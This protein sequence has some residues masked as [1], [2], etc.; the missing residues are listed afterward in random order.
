MD[1][2]SKA[3]M[4]NTLQAIASITYRSEKAQAKF[5]PGN[6]QHTLLKNRIKALYIASSLIE[7][8]LSESDVK[9]NFTK[10]ELE[11]SLCPIASLISKSEKTRQ[12]LAEG[13]WQHRMFVDNLKALHIA[14]LLLSKELNDI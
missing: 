14:L 13:S 7:R 6:S 8:E 1:D 4:E 11:N 5:A 12:K 3:D 9:E 10:K 2:F